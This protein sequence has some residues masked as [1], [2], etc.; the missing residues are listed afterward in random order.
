MGGS[1]RPPA[2]RV[3]ASSAFRPA[4]WRFWRAGGRGPASLPWNEGDELCR[5][6][7]YPCAFILFCFRFLL[8]KPS[9]RKIPTLQHQ[10][11]S[12]SNIFAVRRV[13]K[14]LAQAYIRRR[15]KK[16]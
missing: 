1:A 6:Q 7:Q 3:F 4:D 2:R 5:G 9:L 10:R 16:A 13:A 8:S 15:K 14:I 11:A 12:V